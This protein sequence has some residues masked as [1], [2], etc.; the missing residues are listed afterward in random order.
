MT[1]RRQ[2]AAI[3]G[4]HQSGPDGGSDSASM[5]CPNEMIIVIGVN[6]HHN[7]M[8]C[9]DVISLYLMCQL[10]SDTLNFTSLSHIHCI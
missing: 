2:V 4:L 8:S 5:P 9:H 3:D 7:V 1:S 10:K 6:D